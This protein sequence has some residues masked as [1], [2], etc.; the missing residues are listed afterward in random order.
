MSQRQYITKWFWYIL[1]L[2]AGP[3]WA[4]VRGVTLKSPPSNPSTVQAQAKF[5]QDFFSVQLSPYKIEFGHVCEDPNTWEQRYEKKDFKNHRDMGKVRWG[6]KKGGYGEHYWDLNHAGHTGNHGNDGYSS[7]HDEH[8]YHDSSNDP[9]DEPS[10]HSTSYSTDEYDPEKSS[11]EENGRAKR[12]HTRSKS[13]NRKSQK[14]YYEDEQE[15]A[16]PRKLNRKKAE[17]L[18]IA[19]SH[20][21]EEY[22]DEDQ[23]K[24][25]VVKKTPKRRSQNNQAQQEQYQEPKEEKNQI[26]LVVKENDNS[27]N[28]EQTNQQ[29]RSTQQDVNQY[30]PYEGGAGVRQHRQPD[31]NTAAVAPRL[32]LEHATGRVVDRATGQAYILQPILNNYQ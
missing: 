29:I 32:F 14:E 1:A 5:F 9:Y 21:V 11:Y 30:V 17:Q 4:P 24:V 25:E 7:D 20:K 13:E 15:Q 23:D 19:P 16:K 28:E 3:L 6:D 18:E 31:L 27:E 8:P 12:A 22:S 26:V 10:E 2:S